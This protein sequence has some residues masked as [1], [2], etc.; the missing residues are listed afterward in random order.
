MITP[1]ERS[2][3]SVEQN[4]LLARYVSPQRPNPPSKTLKPQENS[5][6]KFKRIIQPFPPRK[7]VG[8]NGKLLRG[9]IQG[10]LTKSCNRFCRKWSIFCACCIKISK[11]QLPALP[12]SFAKCTKLQDLLSLSTSA[13]SRKQNF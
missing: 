11:Y 6:H 12:L 13:E 2:V 4:T 5:Q 1:V 10:L 7:C 8:K 9:A 3:A